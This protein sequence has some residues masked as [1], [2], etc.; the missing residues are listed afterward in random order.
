MSIEIRRKVLGPIQTN[1]YFVSNKD[2]KECV[3]ID[4]ADDAPRIKSLI[5]QLGVTPVAILLT[6]GH[7]DHINAADEVRSMYGVKI[8]A[9]AEEK[10]TL[11]DPWLNGDARFYRRG[12]S[13]GADVLFHDGDV[14]EFL[15][16]KWKVIW[17]PGHTAG[18]CCFYL[19]DQKILF[20]GDTLF[21]GSYGRYDLPGGDFS[22]LQVSLKK[23]LFALPDDVVV[24]PGHMEDTT[25]GFE[26]RYNPII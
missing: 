6:H 13:L 17:T 10:E 21:Q 1:V 12:L 25:I 20:A 24:F 26:K 9:L 7:F 19:E 4:P 8:Y 14:L 5:D 16:E 22:S 23:K 3:I 15:G 11:S 2:T 18:S